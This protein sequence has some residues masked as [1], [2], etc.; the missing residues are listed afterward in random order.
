MQSSQFCWSHCLVDIN[1]IAALGTNRLQ[2]HFDLNKLVKK[3]R[4]QI[5][6]CAHLHTM[7]SCKLK[8]REQNTVQPEGNSFKNT[9]FVRFL[10]R[11]Q[12]TRGRH[13]PQRQR[14]CSLK[15]VHKRRRKPYLRRTT[16]YQ[17][18]EVHTELKGVVTTCFVASRR[19]QTG[20]RC[21][22]FIWKG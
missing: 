14:R 20:T 2:I 5:G 21:T 13:T 22:Y 16:N 9:D 12:L 17:R 1:G 11:S 18:A 7:M 8:R 10:K 3:Y 4:S 19:Q 15:D 6:T